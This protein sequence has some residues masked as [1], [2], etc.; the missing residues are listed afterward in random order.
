ML[1]VIPTLGKD[2]IRAHAAN[3]REHANQGFPSAGV[4]F[5]VNQQ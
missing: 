2:L 4:L 5:R 1:R 3:A